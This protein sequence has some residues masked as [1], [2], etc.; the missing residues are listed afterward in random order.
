MLK[1]VIGIICIV[2]F[3]FNSDAQETLSARAW[4]RTISSIL[5]NKSQDVHERMIDA[6]ELLCLGR[7][8]LSLKE[9]DKL[10]PSAFSFVDSVN[11]SL[12]ASTYL[13]LPAKQYILKQTQKR[14]VLILNENHYSPQHRVFASSLL[15]DLYSQG[16]RYLAVEAIAGD[17]SV[18]NSKSLQRS[19]GF[20]QI[21]P[22]FGNYLKHAIELGF[23]IIGY[24]A[25]I[26]EAS[27]RDFYQAKHI[28]EKIFDLDPRAKVFIYSG[29]A[30]GDERAKEDDEDATLGWWIKNLTGID[31][32]T[33]DQTTFT[34]HSSRAFENSS[35]TALSNDEICIFANPKDSNDT[36]KPA[37]GLQGFDLYIYHPRTKYINGRPNWLLSQEGAKEYVPKINSKKLKYPLI[38]TAYKAGDSIPSDIP[39]DAIEI[40]KKHTPIPL[41][42]SK[43]TFDIKIL[44]ADGKS[45]I[46]RIKID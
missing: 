42:L 41:I 13:A 10:S 45:S 2:T 46:C 26:T 4:T 5:A 24:E 6:Y 44:D 35:Y 9:I 20:Y 29:L 33:C 19:N 25:D 40:L 21:E 12:E 15:D 43:G 23:T 7:Y 1:R 37:S 14:Q 32:L 31:P 18:N 16:F 30:H 3:S 39:M 28:K 27:K 17:S 34:E 22:C 36:Y 11:T 8:D 38:I